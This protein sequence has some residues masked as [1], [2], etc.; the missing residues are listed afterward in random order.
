[1]PVGACSS[2]DAALD[3]LA[4]SVVPGAT[5]D[6]VDQ[7]LQDFTRAVRCVASSGAPAGGY[8]KPQGGEDTTVKKTLMRAAAR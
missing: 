7:S 6:K 3:A 4:R 8:P 2:V 1:V 5:E